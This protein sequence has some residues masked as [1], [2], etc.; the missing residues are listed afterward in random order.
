[1]GKRWAE[2]GHVYG[3]YRSVPTT[4]P[5]F[6]NEIREDEACVDCGMLLDPTELIPMKEPELRGIVLESVS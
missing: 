6:R 2:L 4:F 5:M 1:M 3:T